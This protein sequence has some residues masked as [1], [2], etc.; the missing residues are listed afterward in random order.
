M[1]SD[2]NTL[3]DQ[4]VDDGRLG[5]VITGAGFLRWL[6][7]VIVVVIVAEIAA[8][9]VTSRSVDEIRWYDAA[10][11]QRI[12]LLDDRGDVVDVT[13]AGT[14]AAWQA[15]VPAEFTSATG[16]SSLNVGLAGAVPTVMG[17]WITDE[18]APRSSPELVVWGLTPLDFSPAYGELQEEAY[19]T[20]VETAD[21]WLADLD[22]S[23][24]SFSTLVSSRRIL[25]SPSDLFGS[26]ETQ[27]AVDLAA[28][29]AV[30]GPDGE[31]IDFDVDVGPEGPAIQRSRLDG[32]DIDRRDVNAVIDAIRTLQAAGTTVVLVEVPIPDRFV[33]QLPQPERDLAAARAAIVEIGDSTA[34]DV[35]LMGDVFGDTNFVDDIHV[36]A[37][38]ATQTTR[39]L[40]EILTT[41]GPD[42]PPQGADVCGTT[43]VVDDVGFVIP[44]GVCRNA[45]AS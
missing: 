28:A 6:A 29:G 9:G 14:S 11:Q 24:S 1:R 44:I 35:I 34:S 42:T 36:D 19:S 18:V 10:A 5:L 21:G 26:G 7:I 13:F 15:F 20:A 23:V 3:Y 12:G 25:R 30:T 31:R 16:Q 22:R 4:P 17:P 8:R 40:A 27:R 37:D 32:F 38:A 2:T 39:W 45:T 33:D 41:P 43:D